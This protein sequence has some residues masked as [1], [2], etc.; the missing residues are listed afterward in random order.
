MTWLPII[1]SNMLAGTIT[2][3]GGSSGSA[4]HAPSAALL[5]TIPY[6]FGGASTILLAWHADRV[7][8]RTLHFAAVYV[9]GGAVLACFVPMYSAAFAAGFVALVVGMMAVF[10]GQPVMT[11]RVRGEELVARACR[12]KLTL[13]DRQSARELLCDCQS[14]QF[15]QNNH[16]A[17]FLLGT[18]LGTLAAQY[19]AS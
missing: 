4:A 8:E 15:V 19:A 16:S 10:A 13:L 14:R 11:C 9:A 17:S 1:I 7:N 18:A 2:A 5:S 6:V 12:A 3:G